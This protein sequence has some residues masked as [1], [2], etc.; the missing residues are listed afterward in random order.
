MRAGTDTRTARVTKKTKATPPKTTTSR[1]AARAKTSRRPL[2][3]P[4]TTIRLPALGRWT[5]RLRRLRR[6]P[7]F[8]Y[9]FIG[10][11]LVVV[12]VPTVNWVY[13]VARK[14]SEL[15]F[16]VSDD[17]Y[18]MPSQ[19]WR[20]YGSLFVA[21]ATPIMTPE[22]L[23]ALA[24]QEASGNPVARTY[25]RWSAT[26]NFFE[27]YRPASSAVGMYQFTDGTFDEARHYCIRDHRVIADGPWYDWHSCWFNKLYARVIPSHAV[28]LASSNLDRR[29]RGILARKGIRYASLLQQQELA[30]ITHLCGAGAAAGYAARGLQLRPAQRCGDHDPRQYIERVMKL[31]Q[32]FARLR[33]NS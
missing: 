13:Q 22:L 32:T 15:F 21:H 29:V 18:K 28:E 8:V 5:E 23:A 2:P 3:A 1:P 12:L 14:P 20:D 25:W 17:W 33:D 9:F 7:G 24:Q 26:S 10:V 31:A 27:I 6:I 11:V 16:P 30:I 19:T 4:T